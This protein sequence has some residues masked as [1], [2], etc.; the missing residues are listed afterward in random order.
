ML[1][2]SAVGSEDVF[3][4]ILTLNGR[5]AFLRK[6]GNRTVKVVQETVVTLL[7]KHVGVDGELLPVDQTVVEGTVRWK[8]LLTD[9][10]VVSG[11]VVRQ[12]G[13]GIDRIGVVIDQTSFTDVGGT[14]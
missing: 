5:S 8:E 1:V 14:D 9:R 13:V 4:V 12:T 7:G 11:V 6:R 10:E 3:G 2:E